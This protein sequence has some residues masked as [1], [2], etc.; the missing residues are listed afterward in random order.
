VFHNTAGVSFLES[1]LQN[2]HDDLNVVCML[3]ILAETRL[4]Q[5]TT[6]LQEYARSANEVVASNARRFLEEM[7]RKYYGSTS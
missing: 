5:A 6:I 4:D 7:Q 2:E 1:R 3:Q